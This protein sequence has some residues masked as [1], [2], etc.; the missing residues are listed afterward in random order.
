MFGL[1]R[2]RLAFHRKSLDLPTLTKRVLR[3][4]PIGR[5]VSYVD[6][7]DALQE[8]PWDV[9][10]ACKDLVKTGALVEGS[11]E[12]RGAFRRTSLKAIATD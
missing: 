9:H 1:D 8:I 5:F 11:D 2:G 7:A 3:I 6:I 4:W 10:E 12:R